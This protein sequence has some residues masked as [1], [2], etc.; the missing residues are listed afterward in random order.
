MN[1]ATGKFVIRAFGRR[2]RR[3]EVLPEPTPHLVVHSQKDFTYWPASATECT[4]RLL[5]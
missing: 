5:A 1:E 4:P 2:A 3:Y